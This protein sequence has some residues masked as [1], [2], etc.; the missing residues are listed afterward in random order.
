MVHPEP[1][2]C[3]KCSQL[4]VLRGYYYDQ[5]MDAYVHIYQCINGHRC[6]KL[7][8]EDMHYSFNHP[9]EPLHPIRLFDF[10]KCDL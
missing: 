6:F 8:P 9:D 2:Y 1:I 10:E 7:Y 5:P 3:L 4:A